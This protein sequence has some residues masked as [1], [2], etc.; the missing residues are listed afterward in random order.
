M[1]RKSVLFKL[2][3]EHVYMPVTRYDDPLRYYYKPLIGKLYVKRLQDGLSMLTP[4]YERVLDFGYGSGLLFNTLAEI[5]RELHGID[6]LSDAKILTEILDRQ[7]IKAQ[8]KQ[9]DILKAGYPDGHF[10]VIVAF[11][12]FEHIRDFDPILKEMQRILKP[13]GQLL[14]GMP[15]VNRVMPWLFKAIGFNNIDDLHVTN[16]RSVLKSAKKYFKLK[17]YKRLPSFLP[18]RCCLYFNMLLEKQS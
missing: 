17:H 6:I 10:D 4:P 3:E 1:A 15:S 13:G 7:N 16:H 5:S 18:D 12:V 11:S 2:P 14:I 8:L 9:E